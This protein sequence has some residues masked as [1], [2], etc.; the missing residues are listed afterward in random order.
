MMTALGPYL[1]MI[2]AIPGLQRDV[3]AIKA[4]LSKMDPIHPVE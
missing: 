4:R 2:N 3:A 1:E